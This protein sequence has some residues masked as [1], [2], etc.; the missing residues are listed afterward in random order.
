MKPVIITTVYAN[1]EVYRAGMASIVRT[2]PDYDKILHA[3]LDNHYPI[4]RDDLRDAMREHLEAHPSASVIDPRSNLGLHGGINRLL[5]IIDGLLHDDDIVVA[6]D[7]DDDPQQVGWLSAM[8]ALFVERKEIGWVSLMCEPGRDVLNQRN[9][10]IDRLN[11]ADVR[12]R[13]PG[14]PLI[15]TVCAWRV[16]ALRECGPIEEPHAYYG[17]IE[18]AMMP[19]FEEAGWRVAWLEDFTVASHR[20]LGDPIYERYKQRHV[21]HVKPVFPGSFDEYIA[22]GEVSP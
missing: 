3:Q 11:S 14:F 7:A 16:R 22:A 4:R 9:V 15:N 19:K 5:Q 12:Y 1:A 6:I 2:V 20:H 18:V 17:G 21:G 10:A 8:M 13:V